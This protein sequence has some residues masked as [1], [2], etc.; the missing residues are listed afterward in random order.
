MRSPNRN[1]V[2]SLVVYDH[3]DYFVVVVM[4]LNI[5]IPKT[6]EALHRSRRYEMFDFQHDH[7]ESYFPA[8]LTIRLQES[9]PAHR[10]CSAGWVR[11]EQQQHVD[12]PTHICVQF[13][14]L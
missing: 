8:V 12:I 14:D 3:F 9:N 4:N 6:V 11:V 7:Q 1:T 10:G 5:I 13:L 2:S